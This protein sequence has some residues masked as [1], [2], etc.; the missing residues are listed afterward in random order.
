MTEVQIAKPPNA[1]GGPAEW[2]EP[3]SL[4]DW[5]DRPRSERGLHVLGSAWEF[6]PY[7]ELAL[8]SRARSAQLLD[9]GICHDDVVAVTA[10]DPAAF[11]AGFFGALHAGA[12]PL[13]IAPPTLLGSRY[14]DHLRGLLLTALPAAVVVTDDCA[15][16]VGAAL[17]ASGVAAAIVCG[18]GDG[19]DPLATPEPPAELA[20][21]QFTSGST[22]RPKGIGVSRCNLESNMNMIRRWL[23]WTSD[24]AVASWLPLYHD[25]GLIGCFLTSIVCQTDLWIMRPEQFV[26]KPLRWLECFGRLGA[27]L[28]AA[29]N[30]GYSHATRRLRASESV[31]MDFAKWRVAI[32]GAERLD[33]NTLSQFS[34]A[35]QP[36]GFSASAFRP[37]YGLAEA[38]L[39]VTGHPLP[40]RP[41]MVSI[42]WSS[43]HLGRKVEIVDQCGIGDRAGTDFVGFLVSSGRPLNGQHV[44]V[45]DDEGN[46][47]PERT[48]GEIVVEG[49]TV[50][51]GYGESPLSTA[52]RFKG[53]ELVTGDAGFLDAGELFVLGRILDSVKVHGRVVYAESIEARLADAIDALPSKCA[54][55]QLQRAAHDELI[56]VVERPPGEWVDAAVTLLRTEVGD[57]LGVRVY[58]APRAIPR[59]TSGKPRRRAL[60]QSLMDGVIDGVCV[61][62]ADRAADLPDSLSD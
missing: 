33:G 46:S 41:R 38:T 43:L 31:G 6:V 19:G 49:P 60:W 27:T 2:L 56:A 28:T 40:L 9:A 7:D 53:S 35:L 52:S 20:L 29:P 8:R 13:P 50:A 14:V 22:A 34:T 54:V 59:T 57:S 47:L 5:I 61:F 4:V 12:T 48:L 26:M 24:D 51:Q 11:L 36:S 3:K 15:D 16:A 39:A 23:E 55:V 42:D 44:H 58:A 30:F 17:V 18:D 21:L 1:G 62:P 10:T 45:V 32:I 25:M 37:A